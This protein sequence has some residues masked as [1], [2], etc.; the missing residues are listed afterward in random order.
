MATVAEIPVV[1]LLPAADRA[2]ALGFWPEFKAM[3]EHT[4]DSVPGVLAI[5]ATY[6]DRWRD[7]DQHLIVIA[8]EVGE[9][10]FHPRAPGTESI[11]WRLDRWAIETFPPEVLEH[12]CIIA[13]PVKDASDDGR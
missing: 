6:D 12:F 4:K 1:I 2:L 11:A 13:F 3:L 9:E 8:A 10:D 5:S 7:D